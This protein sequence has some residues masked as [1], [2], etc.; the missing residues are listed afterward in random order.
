MASLT[1]PILIVGGDSKVGRPLAAFLRRA[2]HRVITTTRRVSGADPDAVFLD[3]A[4]CAAWEPPAGV[5]VAVLAA[6]VTGIDT[7]WQDPARAARVNVDG[8]LQVAGRLQARGAFLLYLSSCA[9]YGGDRPHPRP[10]DPVSPRTVYGRQKAEAERRLRALDPGVAIVRF[11]KILEDPFPLFA[12]WQEALRQGQAIEPFYDM[13]MAPIPMDC[14]VSVLRLIIDSRRGG[15]FHVSGER[16]LTYAEIAVR[17][18]ARVGAGADLIRPIS[19]KDSG[20]VRDTVP[21]CTALNS[22]GVRETFGVEPPPVD[23]TIGQALA[24]CA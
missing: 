24:R 12:R 3:L 14:A 9:V 6:A 22:D 18:A 8:L 5:G 11:G 17:A 16:D 15:V 4:D 23:W 10:D 21:M 20:R 7:C 2:G 19:A 1:A 13:T